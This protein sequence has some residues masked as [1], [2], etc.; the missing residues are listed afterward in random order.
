MGTDIGIIGRP[1]SV[2]DSCHPMYDE[3]GTRLR[4]W[5]TKEQA[6]ERY[7]VCATCEKLTKIKTCELCGCFVI[8]KTKLAREKC[9]EGKW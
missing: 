9:P 8:G 6:Q 5:A 2:C 4:F 1:V 7:A 3:H